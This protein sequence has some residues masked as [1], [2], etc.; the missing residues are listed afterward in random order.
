MGTLLTRKRGSI[1]NSLSFSPSY[2]PGMI[3]ILLKGTENSKTS[4][5]HP[6]RP[7]IKQMVIKVVSNG[8]SGNAEKMP[9]LLIRRP[10]KGCFTRRSGK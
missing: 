7:N 8:G 4:I 3:E 1:V 5:N 9:R 6:I 2:S 10:N